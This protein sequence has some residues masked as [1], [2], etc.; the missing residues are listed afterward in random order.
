[1]FNNRLSPMKNKVLRKVSPLE[2]IAVKCDDR[3]AISN[4]PPPSTR[5]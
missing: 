2:S 4:L 3:R 5:S 1:M